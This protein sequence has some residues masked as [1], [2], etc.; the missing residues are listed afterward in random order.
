MLRFLVS[1][2]LSLVCCVGFAQDCQPK[3]SPEQAFLQLKGANSPKPQ[4]AVLVGKKI[5]INTA[6]EAELVQLHG[7]GTNKAKAIILYRE[8]IS[9][10][11]SVDDLANVKGI[12]QG[13]VEKNRHLLTVSP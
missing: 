8:Y 5:D 2:V 10:F 11:H 7:I 12:G 13:I 4:V 1:L 3:L 6:T 9:R